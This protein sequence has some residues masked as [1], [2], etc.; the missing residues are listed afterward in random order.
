M[1]RL[2][3]ILFIVFFCVNIYA[4]ERKHIAIGYMNNNTPYEF[5]NKNGE[6]DGFCIELIKTIF[7][8]T[9]I[10]LKFI[11]GN[12]V[13]CIEKLDH[14][15]ID[16]KALLATPGERMKKYHF[17]IPIDV[18]KYDLI[19]RNTE[20]YNSIEGISGKKIIVKN[21][22]YSQQ[23]IESFGT[24]F[25]KNLIIVTDM[26]EG[27]D[28]LSKGKADVA[29][30]TATNALNIISKYEIN[31][32]YITESEIPILDFC[33][34]SNDRFLNAKIN[35]G[36]SALIKSGEY[37]RL[38]YKWFGKKEKNKIPFYL[39]IFIGIAVFIVLM[40]VLFMLILKKQVN[41]ATCKLQ[42]L[43]ENLLKS[44]SNM[45]IIFDNIPVPIYMKDYN[46]NR[47]LY[48]NKEANKQFGLKDGILF[49]DILNKE[50]ERFVDYNEKKLLRR[51]EE[52]MEYETIKLLDG[53]LKDTY[54][55]T[56]IVENSEHKSILTVRV[57]L[58]EQ[59]IVNMAG[60]ALELSLSALKAFTWHVDTREMKF[61]SKANITYF[62]LNIAIKKVF[63]MIYKDD[64]D[65]VE[66]QYYE[67]INNGH[68][69]GSFVFRVDIGQEDVFEWWET[70]IIVENISNNG[71][72]YNMI[73][74]ISINVNSRIE[75]ELALIKSKKE[76]KELNKINEIV[77]NN[78][79]SIFV[80]L[81]DNYNLK[82][83]N[84][85]EQLRE[86]YLVGLNKCNCNCLALKTKINP[87]ERCILRNSDIQK[88]TITEEV[89]FDDKRFFCVTSVPIIS[90]NE[91]S[92]F[93]IKMDD[94]TSQK[95][96][97]RNLE[98]AKEKAVAI[99]KMKTAFLANM[100]HEIRTPLNAI[101]GF[102]D[103][104]KD[105]NYEADKEMF[106]NIIETNSNLLLRLIND[107]LD[108]SKMEAGSMDLKIEDFDA[109]ELFNQEFKTFC[110]NNNN[111]NVEFFSETNLKRCIVS[112]DRSRFMQVGINF[113]SNA[114]KYT[115]KGQ[116]IMSMDYIDSGLKISVKDTGI[117]I[118]KNIQHLVFKR[119][120]KLDSF[121][122]GS[123]LGL[124]ICKAILD[125]LG[126]KIGFQSEKNIGSEFWAWFPCEMKNDDKILSN[127]KNVEYSDRK[128]TRLNSSHSS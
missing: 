50:D 58:T 29:V 52:Y 26:V 118:D 62:N 116:I 101:V 89:S 117:G 19:S 36:L 11:E 76:L 104:L 103:L 38:Y 66:K 107:I 48:H 123:G 23:Y 60:K 55:K 99:D 54:L 14:G 46:T 94:V 16:I 51:D 114:F 57:D 53:T 2:L 127:E 81:D 71:E 100:S 119:F 70:R 67:F 45:K 30:S 109:V 20:R 78:S 82:W 124:S 6:P 128:S 8:E 92:G 125:A 12:L 28:L 17:S 75:N 108:L 5:V 56:I 4:D 97:I 68:K 96:L 77:L 35:S 74:G 110:N 120:E 86:N 41:K 37:E 106:I 10:D 22:A 43:N 49:S 40:L 98:I 85:D 121:A 126:G 105:E 112:L 15:K 9:D 44:E 3:I 91:I 90:E 113:L 24:E 115:D 21:G 102:S 80:Y 83:T 79:N 63:S 111:P 33:Y 18:F 34:A 73:Y 7:S 59:N 42:K 13:E 72:N 69:E 25:S 39:L 1:K 87:C 61:Y 64:R 95:E 31:N 32:L 47:I 88:T 84:G 93:V 27:L 122:Q 65:A